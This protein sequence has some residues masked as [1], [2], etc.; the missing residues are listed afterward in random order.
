[1][2][3][4]RFRHIHSLY[5][6]VI[7]A[8]AILSPIHAKA[9]KQWT[10]QEC[11][12]YAV[13]NN[14]QL[15]QQRNIIKKTEL[16][17]NTSKSSRLPNLIYSM[18]QNFSYGRSL[19]VD[20][21][22][23]NQN[24]KTTSFSLTTELPLF[25]GFRISNSIKMNMLSSMA[26]SSDE[27]KLENLLR[28]NVAEAYI[29][30]L[31]NE[32]AVKIAAYQVETDSIQLDR[33]IS[34]EAAGRISHIDVSQQ[35]SI[36]AQSRQVYV[37][38]Y[39]NMQSSLLTLAQLMNLETT[40]GFEICTAMSDVSDIAIGSPCE[41][42]EIALS[43]RPEI[44]AEKQRLDAAEKAI[45]VAKSYLYPQ[46]SLSGGINTR[47]YNTSEYQNEDFFSQLKNKFNRFF[48]L[49]LS[50]PLFNRFETRNNINRAKVERDDQQLVLENARNE[51]YKA[52]QQSYYKAVNAKSNYEA[53]VVAV[54]S[55]KETFE[56]IKEKYENGR[57]TILEYEES[58]RRYLEAE[59]KL[60][61]AK[62]ELLLMAKT[63]R[64]YCGETL[65]I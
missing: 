41:I 2:F 55:S 29:Q 52:V 5:L 23:V 33:C 11:T 35:K 58:K 60:L 54:S 57:A 15:K 27:E 48:S 9:K 31:Y 49:N 19:S 64:F 17:L 18:S 50:F 62:Y 45:N 37:Q 42:Y 51:L 8:F 21:V 20:N 39:T 13:K 22:Y 44:K 30:V 7:L 65:T 12:E 63:L 36:L 38:N 34:F 1:M 46:L 40:E 26:C 10:L 59:S 47:Y 56:L 28:I 6:H 4:A 53:S 32:E 25:T 24:V 61:Q 43:V 14:I 16:S 3:S